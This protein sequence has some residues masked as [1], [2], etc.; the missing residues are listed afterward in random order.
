[1]D[2]IFKVGEKQIRFDD[3][4]YNTKEYQSYWAEICPECQKKYKDILGTR[5]SL[6][7]AGTCSVKGCWNEADYYVDFKEEEVDFVENG[8]IDMEPKENSTYEYMTT[9]PKEVRKAIEKEVKS[10]YPAYEIVNII[11][12]KHPD[13]NYLYRVVAEK[14]GQDTYTYWDCF[15]TYTGS[16]NFGHYNLSYVEAMQLI[17]E[18]SC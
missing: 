8:G 7:A 5:A 1:M 2:M 4:E 14:V 3:Y 13:D 15:N 17:R 12:Y 9:I 16:L 10:I 6:G 18:R 11:R